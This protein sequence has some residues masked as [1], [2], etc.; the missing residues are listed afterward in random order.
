VVYIFAGN[1]KGTAPFEEGRM[2]RT[3]VFAVFASAAL[4]AAASVAVAIPMAPMPDFSCFMHNKK[5]NPDFRVHIKLVWDDGAVKY[6]DDY[7]DLQEILKKYHRS[8]KEMF[9]YDQGAGKEIQASKSFAVTQS[10][11]K[12]KGAADDMGYIPFFEKREDADAFAKKNGGNVVVV[13]D[14]IARKRAE[15]QQADCEADCK[16]KCSAPAAAPAPA[17]PEKK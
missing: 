14:Y 15:F 3:A 2:K 17:A 11:W 4:I 12:P 9:V 8:I 16:S 13:G 1:R 10:K 5:I 7:N 6:T